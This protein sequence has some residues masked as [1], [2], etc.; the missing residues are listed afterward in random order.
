MSRKNAI[1][2]RSLGPPWGPWGG[3]SGLMFRR[4]SFWDPFWGPLG[5]QKHSF[6][7]RKT[8][9]LEILAFRPPE[10]LRST[11]VRLFRPPWPLFG[12]SGR[13][14]I[15]LGLSRGP[16]WGGPK[17]VLG[18]FLGTFFFLKFSTFLMVDFWPPRGAL[19]AP[20]TPQV[21]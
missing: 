9:I 17:T 11:P 12:F 15:F 3:L 7:C 14:Q 18:C 4:G 13:V 20:R 8:P 21:L 2:D 5:G 10:G 16:L 19:L 1:L 6:Y